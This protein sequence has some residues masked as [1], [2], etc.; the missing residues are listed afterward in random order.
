MRAVGAAFGT[1]IGW[2][3]LLTW[4]TTRLRGD[5]APADVSAINPDAAHVNVLLYGLSLCLAV[6]GVVGWVLLSP[7]Q[8]GFRRVGLTMVGVLGGVSLGMLLTFWGQELGGPGALLGLWVVGTA[9]A[10][11]LAR[12]ARRAA[13]E[14]AS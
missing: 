10:V 1:A 7:V 9:L 14:L 8:S 13:R 2:L 11:I 5:A 4:L 12:A 6:T 3:G